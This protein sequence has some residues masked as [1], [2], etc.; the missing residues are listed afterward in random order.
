MIKALQK[1]VAALT[2]RVRALSNVKIE[3]Y[4]VRASSGGISFVRGAKDTLTQ[5]FDKT[6]V[7]VRKPVEADAT[8]W[9]REAKYVNLPPKPCSGDGDSTTC[10]Y[11]WFGE[12]FDAYPPLG[13]KAI[14]YAGDESTTDASAP[15]KL[16]T[17]FH[18]C[19]REHNVWIVDQQAKGGGGVAHC[20]VREVFGGSSII[21]IVQLVGMDAGRWVVQGGAVQVHAKPGM[22]SSNYAAFVH[23]G[24]IHQTQTRFLPLFFTGGIPRLGFELDMVPQLLSTTAR[25]TDCRPFTRATG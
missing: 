18:R 22:L 13:V 19:H 1:Q 3:G 23:Q 17:V 4:N 5:W 21:V 12:D 16:T 6:V 20:V 11:E 7:I 14:S 8:L 9:V 15:P 10:F 24:D 25:V 2:E